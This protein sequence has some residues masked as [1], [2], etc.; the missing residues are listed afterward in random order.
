MCWYRKSRQEVKAAFQQEALKASSPVFVA[1]HA[2]WALL[3]PILLRDMFR[4]RRSGPLSLERPFPA[5]TALVE[6]A[7]F[8]AAFFALASRSEN[9]HGLALTGL[10][11]WKGKPGCAQQ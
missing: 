3:G 9:A 2:R 8:Y 10:L 6:T 4:S 5:P 7:G 1:G 11:C